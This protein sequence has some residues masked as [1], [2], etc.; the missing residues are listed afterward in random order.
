MVSML[1]SRPAEKKMKLNIGK[2]NKMNN[3]QFIIILTII[4]ILMPSMVFA[5]DSQTQ[6]NFQPDWQWEVAVGT[7][8]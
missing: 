8:C 3:K 7:V 2:N 4:L 6:N 5:G 1:T